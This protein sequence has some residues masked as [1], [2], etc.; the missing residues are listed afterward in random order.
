M[1]RGSPLAV[2]AQTKAATNTAA[3]ASIAIFVTA[4]GAPEWLDNSGNFRLSSWR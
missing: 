4:R 2:P 3:T 1:H